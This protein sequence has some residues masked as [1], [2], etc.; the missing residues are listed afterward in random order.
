MMRT[1]TRLMVRASLHSNGVD[2][3]NVTAAVKEL[4]SLGYKVHRL[5]KKYRS[6]LARQHDDMIE[7]VTNCDI[8]E[9]GILDVINKVDHI[10]ICFGGGV[11][12]GLHI[13]DYT[14]FVEF[15]FME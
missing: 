15:R 1:Q 12:F 13:D 2:Q 10:T 8:G 7:V 6:R 3:I 4:S 14:P 5:P 9:R 11:D